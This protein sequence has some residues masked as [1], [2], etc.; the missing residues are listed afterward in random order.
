MAVDDG[1]IAVPPRAGAGAPV[2]LRARTTADTEGEVQRVLTKLDAAG[3]HQRLL[4]VLANS[5]TA[6]RPF[7]LLTS[8]LLSSRHLPRRLQEVVILHLAARLGIDYEWWEHVPMATSAGVT[9]EAVERIWANSGV[10][11]DGPEFGHAERVAVRFADRVLDGAA[12][13]GGVWADAAALWGADGALDL[14]MTVGV[15]GAMVPTVVTGLGLEPPDPPDSPQP[16][17][18]TTS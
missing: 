11:V 3:A 18:T 5:D 10:P 13:G 7:V 16:Q 8:G 14:L 4:R 15:W 2:P 1:G 9:R 6:F 17:G 12:V